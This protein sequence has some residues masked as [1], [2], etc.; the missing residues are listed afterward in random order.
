MLIGLFAVLIMTQMFSMSEQNKRKITSGGDAMNE[1]VIA[2]YAVQRDVRMAGYGVSDVKVMGCNLLLRAGVTLN[3]LAPLTINHASITGQDANTDTLV[4]VYGNTNGS[5]QGDIVTATGNMV[6]TPSAFAANDWVIEAPLVAA[7]PCNLTL[8]QVGGV[9]GAAVTIASGATLGAGNTLFNLGQS[10]KVLAYA[11]RGGNLTVCDYMSND[12]GNAANNGL[13]AVWA[14]IANNI[15][16]LRA[17]YGRKTTAPFTAVDAYDQNTPTTACLWSQTVA[18]RI[19]LVARS[20]QPDS[21]AT[22]AAPVWE[23][24]YLPGTTTPDV[25]INLSANSAWTNYRYRMFQTVVPLRNVN[26]MAGC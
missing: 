17:Q 24:T 7:S 22:T 14:P 26:W 3:A 4:V 13:S 11:I 10:L 2:L 16:S 8:A 12:C 23:G 15:V 9:A 20:A 21:T 5:P 19:A 25:P 18:M 1:G 6:Q